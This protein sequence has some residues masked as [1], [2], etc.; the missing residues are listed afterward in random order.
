MKKFFATLL[1]IIFLAAMISLFISCTDN[2]KHESTNFVYR[3][4][5]IDIITID[6]CQYLLFSDGA[7]T[8]KG[9]CNNPIHTCTCSCEEETE[10]DSTT[11]TSSM[12]HIK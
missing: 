10:S 9:N 11:V 4:S 1:L 7:K 6:E 3:S 8:H 2:V 12:A 5:R